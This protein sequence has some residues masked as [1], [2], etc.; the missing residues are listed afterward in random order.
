M[1]DEEPRRSA[2]SRRHRRGFWVVPFAFLAV[3]AFG[4]GTQFA[5]RRPTRV[6]RGEYGP[7]SGGRLGPQIFSRRRSVRQLRSPPV[8]RDDPHG[9]FERA[10]IERLSELGDSYEIVP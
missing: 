5:L 6:L 2:G 8:E 10:S 4:D 7:R 3:M 9:E 1:N